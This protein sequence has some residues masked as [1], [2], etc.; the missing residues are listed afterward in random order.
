MSKLPKKYSHNEQEAFWKDEW[1]K[2][3]VY[4]WNEVTSRDKVFSVDTPPPTV[5]GS[6]HIG[7]VFSYTHTDAIARYQRMKG[8]NVCY[9]MGWDD[10]GLPTERRVQNVYGIRCQVD[11]AYEEGLCFNKD[12][13]RKPHEFIG[14]SRKN[15]IEACEQLTKEDEAI[16]ES[17]WRRLGLS[18]DWNL[19]YETINEHCRAM[20]QR[21]FLDCVEKGVVKHVEAPGMWDIDFQTA[22][23]QA[24]IE[25]RVKPGAYH[26]IRFAVE[27]GDHCVIATTRPELLAACIAVVVHP[28]DRRYQSMIGKFAITPLFHLRVPIMASTH[29]DP[30]KGTGVVMICTFGDGDDVAW[31]KQSSLPVKQIL[32]RDGKLLPIEFSEEPFN[33]LRPGIATKNYDELVGKRVKKAREAI[34]VLLKEENS[35]VDGTTQALIKDPEPIEHPVKFYEKGDSPV[36]LI[37]T[38]QW[39]IDILSSKK[40]LLAQGNKI[41]WHPEYMKTR[42]QNWVEGLNQDWCISRQRFFGVPFPVWYPIDES[43]VIEYEKPIFADAKQLPVDPLSQS[44]AGYDESQRDQP[45]GFSGDPDV[46]DTW[47]T[48]SLTPQLVSQ[49]GLDDNKHQSIFPM[50]IRPQSH[51]I[52]RT[53]A[54]YTI[55]KAW[56]HEKEIP[57]KNVVISGWVLD[58]YR[59]KMSKSKGNVITPEY[60]MDQYSADAIR[61]WACKAR[62]GADTAF[63]EGV[64]AVGQKLTTKLFNAAK[65]VLLQVE[66]QGELS[67]EQIVEPLDCDWMEDVYD[68]IN[69]IT[70][71]YDR[72]DYAAALETTEQLFWTFCDHYIELV[73]GRAYQEEDI[74]KRQSAC[75]TLLET[76]SILCRLLA[77]ILPFITEEV[78]GWRF[79]SNNSSI[80]QAIWPSKPDNKKTEHERGI[81]ACA[82][83]V[84][85]EIRAA[86]TQSQKSMKFP[87]QTLA[88]TG[89]KLFETQFKLAE[90]DII[91]AGSVETIKFEA[92]TNGKSPLVK[93]DLAK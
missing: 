67:I 79:S 6:L 74:I 81:F 12:H 40:D 75:A 54:F 52:I 50:D 16:F 85:N 63:D 22:V 61:F 70:Q 55:V 60:L 37:P 91:R 77:P 21:S 86:K 19:R 78:W 27:S 33:S 2:N 7:H 68:G 10:N 71:A 14:V 34:V 51:E 53:W 29:A 1:E 25:D 56:V 90:G 45:N 65:F 28:D 57:W 69:T 3:K 64:F 11:L 89:T 92:H 72:F 47:A 20:S 9:P 39:F 66:D 26:H 43:G 30:E 84:M 82:K 35:S 41:S 44:P 15:F 93:V 4:Q 32:G 59:K 8:K 5:S 23:A 88:I 31:W 87:V 49:W 13:N 24:E 36:E 18:V 17:V 38:R 42:Y 62:L 48:S 46:M 76:L 80:H 83:V 73:K 58:P